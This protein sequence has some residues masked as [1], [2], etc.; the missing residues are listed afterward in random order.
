LENGKTRGAYNVLSDLVICYN[1]AGSD[2]VWYT[3]GR[4][5]NLRETN[6]N[7]PSEFTKE[8]VEKLKAV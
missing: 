1:K 8:M 3:L 5:K 6:A 7:L 2:T 4:E